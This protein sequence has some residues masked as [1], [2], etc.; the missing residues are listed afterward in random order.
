MIEFEI[1]SKD[2]LDDVWQLEQKCFDDPWT[3]KMFESEIDNRVS[4]YI[5]ARDKE[6]DR[7]V[8]FGGV[9]TVLDCA[10]ITDIAV[11]ADYRRCGLGAEIMRLLIRICADR[12]VKTVNLEVKTTNDAAIALYKKMGFRRC[13]LRKRY[14]HNRDDAALMALEIN[15]GTDNLTDTQKD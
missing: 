3:K 14:Y 11:D 15:S 12:G 1:L 2:N 4:V 10:D 6:T 5:A 7:I 13:G 8:G 9:W